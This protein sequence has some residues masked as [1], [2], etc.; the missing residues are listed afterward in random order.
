MGPLLACDICDKWYHS[1]CVK[2]DEDYLKC[3]PVF[4]CSKCFKES[5]FT[6]SSYAFKKYIENG[7]LDLANVQKKCFKENRAQ[8]QSIRS[9]KFCINFKE[10]SHVEFTRGI[11]SYSNRGINNNYNKCYAN[12]SFQAILA[13]SVFDL[14]PLKRE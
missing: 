9:H 7:E 4:T 5:F 14:L 11:K 13:S 10:T 1:S 12:A 8:L 3:M 6:L 2:I